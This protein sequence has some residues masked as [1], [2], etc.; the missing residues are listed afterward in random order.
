[1]F[2]NNDKYLQ[3]MFPEIIIAQLIGNP[4]KFIDFP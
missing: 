1:M 2:V 3:A 4:H